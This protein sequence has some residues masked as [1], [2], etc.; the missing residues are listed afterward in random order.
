MSPVLKY[1][2]FAVL[3]LFAL[4]LTAVCGELACE[5]FVH[6]C[7]GRVDRAE[8]IQRRVATVLAQVLSSASGGFNI[9]ST[10]SSWRA[11]APARFSATSLA[12]VS[13]RV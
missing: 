7:C 13:L 12:S 5:S 1:A 6:A 3:V 8:R 2:C 10:A 4:V 11:L 9:A